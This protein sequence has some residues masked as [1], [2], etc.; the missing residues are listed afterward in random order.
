LGEFG[1]NYFLILMQVLG[2]SEQL[3]FYFEQV[4]QR[5][6]RKFFGDFIASLLEIFEVIWQFFGESSLAFLT[7]LKQVL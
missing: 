3:F 1:G 5:F 2:D 6:W 4:L 7:V